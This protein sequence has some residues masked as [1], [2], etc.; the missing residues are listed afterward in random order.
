MASILASQSRRGKCLDANL[1]FAEARRWA[2][3]SSHSCKGN[4]AAPPGRCLRL[5]A[6]ATVDTEAEG[7]QWRK[8]SGFTS[9]PAQQRQRRME[10]VHLIAPVSG[11]DAIWQAHEG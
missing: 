1:L 6:C 3:F 7:A 9:S 11:V 2:S 10:G 4:T 5:C 8:R